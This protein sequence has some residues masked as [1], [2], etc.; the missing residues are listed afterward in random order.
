[1]VLTIAFM[2]RY[3][4]NP[5]KRVAFS[6]AVAFLLTVSALANEPGCFQQWGE[7]VFVAQAVCTT[8][9]YPKYMGQSAPCGFYGNTA[10]SWCPD[11]SN[12]FGTSCGPDWPDYIDCN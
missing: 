8:T 6:A 2:S 5:V 3:T 7:S 4:N 9:G 1:M 11:S 10:A 12:G